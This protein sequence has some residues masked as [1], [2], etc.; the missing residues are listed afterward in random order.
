MSER[1]DR[2]PDDKPFP[3]DKEFDTQMYIDIYDAV[4]DKHSSV[5]LFDPVS[6][7]MPNMTPPSKGTR[8]EHWYSRNS[9]KLQ[10]AQVFLCTVIAICQILILINLL[11]N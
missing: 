4:Q 11:N 7:T 5:D 8:F 2:H 6:Q 3:S 9:S 10:C 1:E